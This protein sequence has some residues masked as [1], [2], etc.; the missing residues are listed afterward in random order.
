M[1]SSV[2]DTDYFISNS[3]IPKL[4]SAAEPYLN[5]KSLNI[6]ILIAAD[7]H[8]AFLFN[9]EQIDLLTCLD[10]SYIIDNDLSYGIDIDAVLIQHIIS[11]GSVPGIINVKI[12]VKLT[13]VRILGYNR[14]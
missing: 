2:S 3:C 13:E 11:P 8:G 5:A 9:K 6:L 1:A 7:E 4:L 12:A 10:F 14:F